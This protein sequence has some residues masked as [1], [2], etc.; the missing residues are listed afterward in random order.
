MPLRPMK[1]PG[2]FAPVIDMVAET[3]Q[4]P[5]NPEWG[6]QADEHQ[7]MAREVRVLQRVWPL[8]RVLQALSPALR[9]VFGGFVWE[10][11]G[12]IAGV[13]FYERQGTT[14]SW[15]IST[16]GVH[17]EYRRRGIARQLVT[18]V[19][20]E[21]RDRGGVQTTLGVIDRNVPAYSLYTSLGFEP[22]STTIEFERVSDGAPEVA[23]WPREYV[24]E[25]VAR[26]EDWRVQYELDKRI[27]PAELTRY[28]PVV[29]GR[30]REPALLRPF[31]P[32]RRMMQRREEKTILIRSETE[33][34]PVAWGL[35]NVPKRPG[36]V[37]VMKIRLDP[38]CPQLADPL[39]AHHLRRVATRAPGRRVTFGV[40]EWM[41][42]LIEAAERHGFTRRVQYHY[43][44]LTL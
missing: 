39:V 1:L 37:C 42:S 41:P 36:G 44:G 16:V 27:S 18:R 28:Q 9:N 40:A 14:K 10:E 24:R 20:E 15:Q 17:P 31:L 8:F 23:E 29:P 22:Y 25:R 26:S 3:F 5:E 19:L 33:G 38:E 30:Y 35:Y 12:R 34:R 6:I 7:D 43:Q 2:D 21:L 11:A 4:Y 32:I 13:V